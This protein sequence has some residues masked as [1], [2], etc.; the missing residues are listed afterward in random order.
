MASRGT[1]G[2]RESPTS[3]ECVLSG[4]LVHDGIDGMAHAIRLSSMALRE[5]AA[6]V[7]SKDPSLEP[8][9]ATASSV[10]E[11][12]RSCNSVR[13]LRFSSSTLRAAF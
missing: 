10:S 5:D 13:S 3:D 12:P 6:G 2:V 1:A 11:R 8:P 7:C 4:E 9:M